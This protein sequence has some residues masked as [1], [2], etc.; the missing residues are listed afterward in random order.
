MIWESMCYFPDV[1]TFDA[2]NLNNKK[3]VKH[4]QSAIMPMS[5]IKVHMKILDTALLLIL[6]ENNL[7]AFLNE[8][9]I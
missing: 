5:Y 6:I 3:Y 4:Y 7:K 9:L 1:F 8:L 2:R